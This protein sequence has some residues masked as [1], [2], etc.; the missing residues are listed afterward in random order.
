MPFK[1]CRVLQIMPAAPDWRAVFA[2]ENEEGLIIE[3]QLAGAL[4]EKSDGNQA[5]VGFDTVGEAESCE[6]PENF[7]GYAA[8]GET[9][10]RWHREALRYFQER[11]SAFPAEESGPE[12]LEV[13][14]R[15]YAAIERHDWDAVASC[16]DREADY[17]DPEVRVHGREA[18]VERAKALEAPFVE[19]SMQSLEAFA[20]T[21]RAAVTWT[22][23]ARNDGRIVMPDG[24]E[25]PATGRGV[26]VRGISIF[27]FADGRIV[28][29]ESEWDNAAVFHQLGLLPDPALFGSW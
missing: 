8:P 28:G 12:P 3:T 4:I 20:S 18:V 16:Y 6:S 10:S 24:V 14:R 17:A 11:S 25:M 26:E 29:E 2:D 9:A 13:V 23:R 27:R 21:D 5:V 7:L 22:Y 15:L 19:P 1:N